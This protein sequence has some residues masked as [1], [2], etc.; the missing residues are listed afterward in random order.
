[1][2]EIIKNGSEKQNDWAQK[3]A[4]NWIRKIDI[5]IESHAFRVPEDKYF[6]ITA[7]L[8]EYKSMAV[9]QLKNTEAKTII[10]RYTRQQMLDVYVI[11]NAYKKIE[12]MVKTEAGE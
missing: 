11:K 3:I 12:S 10:D 2:I 5:E 9:D 8:N 6:G 1:M 4:D 7:I